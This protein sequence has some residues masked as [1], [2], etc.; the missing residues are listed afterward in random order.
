MLHKIVDIYQ[1]DIFWNILESVEM[2]NSTKQFV[3][4]TLIMYM[5]SALLFLTFVELHIHTQDAATSEV[6]GT[7]VSI[8]TYTNDFLAIS[9][10][11]VNDEISVNPESILKIKQTSASVL[12]IFMLLAV[13]IVSL[14]RTFIGRIRE[15][16]H[17]LPVIAFYGTPPLRA[18]PH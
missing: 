1:G 14:C 18:P 2:R 12:A 8:S 17:L 16:H 3:T 5:V 15:A 4:K 7:A 13:L 10:T 6:H 9:T 11:D